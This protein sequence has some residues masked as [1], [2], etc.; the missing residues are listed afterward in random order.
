M[1]DVRVKKMIK[2]VKVKGKW[3]SNAEYIKRLEKKK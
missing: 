2:E 1:V 3:I